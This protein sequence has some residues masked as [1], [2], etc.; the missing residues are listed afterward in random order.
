MFVIINVKKDVYGTFSSR[1]Q[2]NTAKRVKEE[3]ARRS[4][5][6]T[7]YTVKQVKPL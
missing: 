4:G 5:W 7:R 2:A 1:K 3:N 6:G